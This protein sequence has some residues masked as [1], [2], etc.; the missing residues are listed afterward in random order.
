MFFLYLFLSDKAFAHTFKLLLY[1]IKWL[2]IADYF[3]PT[4]CLFYMSYTGKRKQICDTASGPGIK[5]Q[6][7]YERSEASNEGQTVA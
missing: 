3:G 2:K 7:H 5:T 6:K 4:F 1:F